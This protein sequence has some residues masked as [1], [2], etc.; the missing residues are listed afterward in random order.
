[1][2]AAAWIARNRRDSDIWPNT[3][4]SVLAQGDDGSGPDQFQGYPGTLPPED[5]VNWIEA[6]RIAVD[7]LAADETDDP[8]GGAEFFGNGPGVEAAMREWDVIEPDFE[9]DTIEGTNFHYSNKDYTRR[10][11]TPTPSP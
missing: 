1:M 4:T 7:V 3:I 5:D 11:P 9:W 2:E 10:L 8:T 6:Q